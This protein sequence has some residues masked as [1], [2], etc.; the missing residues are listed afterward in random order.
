MT[1]VVTSDENPPDVEIVSV[2]TTTKTPPHDNTHPS[3]TPTTPVSSPPTTPSKTKTTKNNDKQQQ[4]EEGDKNQNATNTRRPLDVALTQQRMKSWQPLLDSR[5]VIAIYLI[6]GVIFL[7]VGFVIRNKSNRI[8]ELVGIYESYAPTTTDD[9]GGTTKMANDDGTSTT[10]LIKGCE[11]GNNPNAMYK[12]NTTCQIQLQVPFNMGDMQPPVL[13]HY[14][15]DNFYQN[16][17]TYQ[18]SYDMAQLLGSLTQDKVSADL[19]Q[20]LNK[21]RD[22]QTGQEIKINPCGL[23]ANSLFNDVFTLESIVGPDGVE[24]EGAVMN[25]TGIAWKSD[26]QWKY[27][28]PEGFNYEVCSSCEDCSCEGSDWSCTEPYE[29]DGTC[30]RYY[31]PEDDT[32]QYLYETYPMTVSPI[33][34]VLNEHFVVWMRTA[35]LPNFRKLYGYID[36]VIPAGSVL[37]F[38][39]QANW[40]VVQSQ[41]AK[42]LVVSDNYIFGGKNHWLGT[43][44]IIVGGVA[45]VLGVFFLVIQ[46]FFPRKLGDRSYLKYKED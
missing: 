13:V 12:S 41:S 36:V 42:A 16:Y 3:S 37:T 1:S 9:G 18:V 43:L 19:C 31:Y 28:Q 24:I 34:G 22:T 29:E 11:I 44:F 33:E 40:A 17:R 45:A 32:T 4:E 30:Y 23:I 27:R 7:I 38:S 5:Y 46:I 6:I 8:I 10:Q 15:I 21:L 14:Q 26:L 39:V 2:D 25:E 35:A 20:P